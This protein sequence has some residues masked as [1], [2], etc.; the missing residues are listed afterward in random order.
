MNEPTVETLPLA[1]A[2]ATHCLYE[3]QDH[4]LKFPGADRLQVGS[5]WLDPI[6]KDAG[7]FRVRFE[8]QLGLAALQPFAGPRPL[9]APLTVEVLSTKFPTP[10]A[11]LAFFR[12]LLADL[13]ARA[14]RLPFTFTAP[15]GRNVVEAHR[16]PTPLF[17]YHYLRQND[18]ALRAALASVQANPHRVLTDNP[19]NVPLAEATEADADVLLTILQHP[20]DWQRARGFPLAE[21]LQ[22]HAP[23]RVWQRRPR[24]TYD[25][26][27][28]RFVRAFLREVLTAADQ[29]PAQRWWPNVPAPQQHRLRHLSHALRLARQ[30]PFLDA[31]GELT[32]FPAN[33]QVLLRRPGYRELLELWRVFHL[34]RRPLFAALQHALD[35]RNIAQLYEMWAFFALAENIGAALNTAPVIDLS[36]SDDSGL[37]Y[38]AEARFGAA[39]TLHYNRTYR[40]PQSYSVPLRPDFAWHVQ[41]QL[42]LVFDAKFRLE[43][44]DLTDDPA[45][46]KRDDLYKMHAYRDALNVRAALSLYPG[47]V[48]L[49]YPAPVNA[50]DLTTDV[51][52]AHLLRQPLTGIGALPFSPV[53]KE[54]L[55]QP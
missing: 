47:E 37:A 22:G 16:P 50:S 32:H 39:G 46:A 21:R 4:Y 49:F 19:E 53:I 42:E 2:P 20:A 5:D 12:A 41:G 54:G 23:A 33:S 10:A 38:Q 13:F 1:F 3:W 51:T 36:T 18:A 28:N 29:L 55:N 25:T 31:V 48:A 44:R 14:A 26:A 30:Q 40:A 17:I 24:E 43:R 8:N 34:A 52:L 7:L 27:P 11:H 45:T 9:G 6:D 35:V 15:T